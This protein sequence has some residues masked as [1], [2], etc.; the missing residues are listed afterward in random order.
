MVEQAVLQY[1]EDQL[2]GKYPE[3]KHLLQEYHD[4]ILLFDLTDKLVWSK[5]VKDT[6]GLEKFY[7]QNKRNYMWG[8]RMDATIF[9]CRDEDV[10]NFA[11]SLLQK[12]SKKEPTPEQISESVIE[13][14][15]DSTCI[16]FVTDKFEKGDHELVDSIDWN[17]KISEKINSNGKVVFIVNNKIIEPGPKSLDDARGLITADYQTYLEKEWIK[18]LRG[19][20]SIH[21]N[22][23]LLSKIE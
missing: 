7:K 6:T 20:Y 4:G 13:K 2:P 23:E 17:S 9:T 15:N 11:E 1:E 19:K 18:E 22:T 8:K 5:A 16:S 3:Y 21:V 14:F 10:A 12:K